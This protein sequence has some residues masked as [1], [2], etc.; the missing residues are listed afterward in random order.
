M[1]QPPAPFVVPLSGDIDQRLSA[2]VDAINRK[3]DRLAPVLLRSP[4]GTTWA[5]SVDDT[6]TLQTTAVTR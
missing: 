2:I 4:D 6:G 1:A 3:A 5:V